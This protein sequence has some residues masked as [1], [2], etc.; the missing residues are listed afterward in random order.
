MAQFYQRK[1]KF[2]KKNTS[3]KLKYKK[4]LD[5]IVKISS[6]GIEPESLCKSLLNNTEETTHENILERKA[7]IQSI[8]DQIEFNNTQVDINFSSNSI[9]SA[10][11]KSIN[12]DHFSKNNASETSV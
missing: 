4:S 8:N 1:S 12:F 10:I 5:K 3:S 9:S 2:L 6:F 7:S 11:D